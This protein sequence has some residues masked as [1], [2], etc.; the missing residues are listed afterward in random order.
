MGVIGYMVGGEAIFN[1]YEGGGAQISA[2]SEQHPY[3]FTA[4]VGKQ[5]RHRSSMP[6]IRI[7]PRS[8]AG[9]R[10]I[11]TA[12]H[13]AWRRRS[14]GAT[15]RRISWG[16]RSMVSRST[17]AGTST[18]TRSPSRSWTLATASPAP[19]P[20]FPSG[21]YHYVLPIGVT[22]KQ[23][24]L[25]CYSGSVSAIQMAF[26]RKLICSIHPA[27]FA[28]GGHPHGGA[29]TDAGTGSGSLRRKA[30]RV[31]H[32][33]PGDLAAGFACLSLAIEYP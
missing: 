16:S 32:E 1:P 2:I 26:A 31:E 30:R 12:S 29:R 8:P 18:A 20:E 9:T 6:A 3:T 24:S 5:R 13:R 33:T 23:S 25:N 21:V 27:G 19:T 7:P 15:A 28:N 17:A 10:G 4:P 22:G 14:T 11:T